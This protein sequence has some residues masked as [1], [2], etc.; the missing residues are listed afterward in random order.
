MVETVTA[1]RGKGS[2]LSGRASA[3]TRRQT[4][5]SWGFVLPFMLVFFTFTVLPVLASM[6]LS[7]TNFNMIQIPGWVGLDN[8]IRLFLEDD[9]FQTAV[10][11]T[12]FFALLT[13]PVGYILCFVFAWMINGLNPKLRA[14]LTLLFYAPSMMGNMAVIWQI[15]FSGDQYG[16]LNSFLIQLGLVTEPVQ[17]LTDTS[18][19]TAVVVVVVLWSSLGTSFLAFIAGLQNIDGSQLEAAAID[20]VRNR[21]QEPYFII[22]PGMKPQLMFGAVM[23]ISGS[24]GIGAAIT[25]LVGFPSTDYVVHTLVH[26]LEDYGSLRYQMGYASAIA[27]LLF[28]IMVLSNKLVQKIIARVGK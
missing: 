28:A 14:V 13:G 12:L 18:T 11:N 22:L 8:Y 20:G 6:A 23:S 26:H 4:L 10:K 21:W 2:A 19:I 7:L 1:G 9:V 3:R 16:L 15:I 5:I 24:F 25:Q 27:T 17:W